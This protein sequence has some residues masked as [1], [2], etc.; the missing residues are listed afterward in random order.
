[1]GKLIL[2]I[3]PSDLEDFINGEGEIYASFKKD[4]KHYIRVIVPTSAVSVMLYD[5]EFVK[6]NGKETW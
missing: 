2:Y 1:M 6:I 4:K 3:S 5:S